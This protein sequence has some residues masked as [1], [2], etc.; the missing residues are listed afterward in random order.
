M[1]RTAL[2]RALIHRPTLVLADE[3]TENLDSR[4]AKQ[5]IEMP[6]HLGE[7]HG[8]TVLLV[9]HSTDAASHASRQIELLGGSVVSD[10]RL[11]P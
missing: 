4:T 1:Q 8:A 5:V 9:T 2:A 7:K 10:I 11:A 3:P 6:R